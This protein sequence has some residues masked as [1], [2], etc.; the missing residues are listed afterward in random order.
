MLRLHFTVEDL[1]RVTTA[2][3][4]SPLLETELAFIMLGR[5]DPRPG[6]RRWQQQHRHTLP[7][8]VRPLGQLLSP[9][10]AG[11]HFLDPPGYDLDDGLE[12]IMSTPGPSARA[13]LRRMCAM[14]RP[15]TPWIRRL[16]GQDREA[17]GELA[18]AV[19]GAHDHL[20]SSDWSRLQAAFRTDVA[21]RSRQLVRHGLRETI[22]GLSP[23]LRWRGTTL[24]ADY[25]RD[26]DVT[27]GGRGLVLQ[28]SLFW[29]GPPLVACHDDGPAILIHPAL[30]PLPLLDS[31]TDR[32]HLAVL[33]GS[34]RAAVLR[35]LTGQHS[36]TGIAR[37]LQVSAASVSTHTKALREAGLITSLRD[38][39]A[40]QHWCTPLGLDLMAHSEHP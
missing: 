2:D 21:W 7:R 31:P 5:G 27:L 18:E 29:T 4:P 15:L 35:L 38:G 1:L 20:L 8:H 40:V 3:E 34:T 26:V 24:E 19:R 25:P 37:A 23:A 10:G 17:W 39:K 6:V 11:P 33:L 36:T 16:A 14:D 30:T 22:A 32:D 28:P 12:K 13:E 9:G